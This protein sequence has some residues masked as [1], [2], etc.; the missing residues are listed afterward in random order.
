MIAGIMILEN[1]NTLKF[2]KI[3][4]INNASLYFITINFSSYKAADVTL[5]KIF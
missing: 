2:L 5:N 3:Q 1:P 4:T